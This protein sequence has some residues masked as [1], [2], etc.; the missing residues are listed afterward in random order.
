M[1][2]MSHEV[3]TPLNAIN[4]MAY[5]IKKTEITPTQKMYVERIIQ[6][7]NNML[8]IIND[9]LDFSKIEAGKVQLEKIVQHR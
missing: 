3:R 7:S 8:S 9:I 4:G 1:A 6:A 5:L 2:R